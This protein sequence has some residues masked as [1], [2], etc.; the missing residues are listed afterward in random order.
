MVNLMVSIVSSAGLRCH[1]YVVNNANKSSVFH[2]MTCTIDIRREP[3][4][5]EEYDF[6]KILVLENLFYFCDDS[7]EGFGLPSTV[8][9]AS[10]PKR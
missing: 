2:A 8:K 1:P 6:T 3:L 9:T 10:S 5:S 7:F 4:T